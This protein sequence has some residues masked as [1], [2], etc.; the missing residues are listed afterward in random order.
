MGVGPGVGSVD[1]VPPVALQRSGAAV[2]ARRHRLHRDIPRAAVGVGIAV[3]NGGHRGRNHGGLF[4]VVRVGFE[5][6]VGGAAG[7]DACGAGR[8]AV[9]GGSGVGG[10]TG[11]SGGFGVGVGGFVFEALYDF[12]D[13][14]GEDGTG[15]GADP[16]DPLGAVE[17]LDDDGGCEG[18]G[19]VERTAGPENTC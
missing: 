3:H 2:D 11:G 17:F 18:T 10:G 6:L 5:I 4:L 19:W 9:F 15:D 14:D 13:E 1:L 7:V 8:A 12:E 16:V